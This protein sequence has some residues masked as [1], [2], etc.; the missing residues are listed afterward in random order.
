[1][2]LALT[3]TQLIEMAERGERIPRQRYSLH[4]QQ[5]RIDCRHEK[6]WRPIVCNG[7][8]DVCE[9]RTCGAQAVFACN[10]DK[11]FS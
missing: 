1:M 4:E 11:D 5:I 7:D 3:Q 2:S 10:F 6:G 8:K 9:C